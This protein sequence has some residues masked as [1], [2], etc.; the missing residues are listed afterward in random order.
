MGKKMIEKEIAKWNLDMPEL[1]LKE[2]FE[3]ILKKNLGKLIFTTSFGQEDQLLIHHIA[4]EKLPIKVVTLDT[5][6]LFQETYNVFHKTRLLYGTDIQSFYPKSEEIE[7]LILKKG[8][9]SFYESIENRKECCDIR[10]VKPLKKALEGAS[11]WITGLRASQNDNRELLSFFEFDSVFNIIKFNPLLHWNLEE[12]GQYLKKYKVPE[13][14]LHK[15]GYVSIG[16]APC[17]RAIQEG[18]SPRAG[19][20][21]WESSHKECGLHGI[22]Q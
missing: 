22:K 20:W 8:P 14:S 10:K 21:W 4:K 2:A 12:V 18:E 5:G 3:Y 6:R 11:I 13:N 17:T 1:S 7:E 19:R 15:K 9:N 16:C